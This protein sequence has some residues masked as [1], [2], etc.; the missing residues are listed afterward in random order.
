MVKAGDKV[1]N[2]KI[3]GEFWADASHF[4]GFYAVKASGGYQLI[5]FTTWTGNDG[6][7]YPTDT[8]CDASAVLPSSSFRRYRVHETASRIYY[9]FTPAN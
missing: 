2:R 5:R 1:A 8:V 3:V 7:V 4:T 9:G 6:T